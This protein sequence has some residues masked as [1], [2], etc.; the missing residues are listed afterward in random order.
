MNKSK[1]AKALFGKG[2]NCAQSILFTYGKEYFKENSSAFKLASGFGAGISY[3]G[4]MCGAVSGALMIIG[5]NYGC[6][7][8]TV[9]ASKES[10]YKISKEFIEIFNK[11]NGSVLCNK[12]ID[13][14]INTPEGLQYARQKDLFNNICPK[15]V[16]NASEV[17]EFIFQ[18]Y[19]IS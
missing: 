16:E 12:L 8:L 9:D 4:E 17:L 11:Q 14:E 18:K 6:T 19:P 10:L 2:L 13:C 15:L 3:R 5:L 7:D 1:E